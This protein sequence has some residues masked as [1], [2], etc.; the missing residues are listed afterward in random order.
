M[1]V[2][3]L[4]PSLVPRILFL[5]SSS[6]HFLSPNTCLDLLP[7]SLHDRIVSSLYKSSSRSR[8][9]LGAEAESHRLTLALF[10][11][12]S[13][14]VETSLIIAGQGNR[15]G[16]SINYAKNDRIRLESGV[17]STS[18]MPQQHCFYLLFRIL[19]WLRW[20]M[21]SPFRGFAVWKQQ[22]KEQTQYPFR[23]QLHQNDG[24]GSA[25]WQLKNKAN[26]K[27]FLKPKQLASLPLC[28]HCSKVQRKSCTLPP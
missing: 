6:C 10:P 9:A 28:N 17:I 21:N 15:V 20:G 4:A 19:P 26:D 5:Y 7:A 22:G 3:S 2:C 8:E 23:L 1:S 11:Q 27:Q 14:F 12:I 16:T 18:L 24:K 13:C 25:T